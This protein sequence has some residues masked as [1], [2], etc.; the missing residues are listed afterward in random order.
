MEPIEFNLNELTLRGFR[1]GNKSSTHKILALHGWLDNAA[2][3][4]PFV[5]LLDDFDFVAIDL[6]GHGL[7]THRSH[8]TGYHMVDYVL[9][10][11]RVIE[12]LNWNT[13]TLLGHS[14][15]GAISALYCSARPDDIQQLI[16]L[17]AMG[18]LSGAETDSS[19]RL[20]NFMKKRKRVPNERVY[21]DLKS[22]CAARC[23]ATGMREQD[24][25]VIME[26]GMREVKNGWVWRSDRRLLIPSP[27][28]YTEV[29]IKSLLSQINI[30]VTVIAADPAPAFVGE[31]MY[32]DRKKCIEQLEEYRIKA[33]HHLHMEEPE[34]IA[35]IVINK[36]Q[37][38][39]ELS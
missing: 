18:P 3:F 38:A 20:S 19:S 27:L 25:M 23:K 6:S 37:R 35:K 17:D 11:A 21:P 15:G 12:C 24:A 22:A 34:K 30:P 39:G 33:G 31:K 14:M 9:E 36:I 29:A 26:R 13:V 5:H 2:S 28:R 1:F 4:R 8:N 10:V 7:S 32:A 16:M